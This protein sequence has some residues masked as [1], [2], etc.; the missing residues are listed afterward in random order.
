[1]FDFASTKNIN[2]QQEDFVSFEQ[3]ENLYFKEQKD[4]CKSM[5]NGFTCVYEALLGTIEVYNKL[6]FLNNSGIK[7][8]TDIKAYFGEKYGYHRFG[9]VPRLIIWGDR[10][11][12]LNFDFIS[13]KIT[14]EEMSLRMG[15]KASFI[16]KT[17]HYIIDQDFY[18]Y[19]NM[20]SDNFCIIIKMNSSANEKTFENATGGN[21]KRITMQIGTKGPCFD[22]PKEELDYSFAYRAFRNLSQF[23]LK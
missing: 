4:F 23:I 3:L 16:D 14:E 21:T 5:S 6:F 8:G 22:L 10:K 2:P 15:E 7:I 12:V 1:M 13:F 19:E 9:F 17:Y 20:D 11:S 18:L